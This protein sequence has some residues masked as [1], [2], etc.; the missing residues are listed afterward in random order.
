MKKTLFNR[1]FFIILACDIVLLCGSLYGAYLVRF[2][3]SIPDYFLSNL[4]PLVPI[5]LAIKL[6]CFYFFDLYRGM[7]RFTSV[8][9]LFNVIKAASLS[10]VLILSLILLRYRFIGFSRSAFLIDWG[11]TVMAIAGNRLC[12]RIFFQRFFI[13]ATASR[14]SPV[15][16]QTVSPPFAPRRK[17]L[18]I[19]GAGSCGE[20]IFREIR[21]QAQS[22]YD[23]IA[24]LDDDPNKIGKKLHGMP[25]RGGIGDLKFVAQKFNADEALIAIPSATDS[26]MRRVV[27]VC[28][29]SGVNFKTVPGY[30][31]LIDGRVTVSAIREVDYRD[32]LGRQTVS[33]D[34][35]MIE[36]CLRGKSILV[37]GAGGS[38]GAELCRQ[39]AR[40]RPDRLILLDRAE[41][42]LFEI[43]YD[44]GREFTDLKFHSVLG[45]ILDRRLL[46]SIFADHHPRIVFHAAAYKHVPML[47]MQPW[48]AVENNI[49]G[50][51][52]LVEVAGE[53]QIDRLVLV[54]TD[55]AVRP[56]SVMGASKRVAEIVTLNQNDGDTSKT[57]FMAVRFGNVVGSIGSVVPLFKKQ[58]KTGG[59]VTVTHPEVTRFFMTIR[60]ACQLILQAGAMGS[61]GEIFILDMGTP[62]RILDMARD[63]IRLSGFEP[64]VDIPIA[65]TGLR[66]GEKL[67]EEL[68]IENEDVLPTRHQNILTLKG[69]Q[70]DLEALKTRIA[71]LTTLAV[72]RDVDGIR[73][74]LRDVV[75]EY[76][77][78]V[79]FRCH[80]ADVSER[81]AREAAAPLPDGI[82]KSVSSAT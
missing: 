32:L 61:G 7:W 65:Y 53:F 25:V 59:P 75:P 71:E 52:H 57:K 20:K 76:E 47:E 39:I 73:A 67:F 9:D 49:V 2:D 40:F 33:L 36:G 51:N 77:P 21:D 29:D 19:I 18:I 63:L 70:C 81:P 6:V 56:S 45:D 72:H 15:Q 68:M 24:Y 42:P 35:K 22:R 74:K 3:F 41:S 26:D 46:R 34:E 79:N 23:V 50:T 30:G 12:I 37:T 31:E 60:E 54:S 82:I 5:I 64:D 1:N 14:H 69:G 48:K 43:E 55:K 17:R 13:Q 4:L 66:P 38:I 78:A 27:A 10:T 8:A 28:K 62:V 16:P 80:Q 44:L 58:I 11:I